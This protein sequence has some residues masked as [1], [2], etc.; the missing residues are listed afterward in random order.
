MSK[1]VRIIGMAIAVMGCIFLALG[2]ISLCVEMGW[3]PGSIIFGLVSSVLG[4]LIYDSNT[5]LNDKNNKELEGLD[6][7]DE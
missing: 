6:L 3:V 4:S 2:F 1:I 5:P 7:Y